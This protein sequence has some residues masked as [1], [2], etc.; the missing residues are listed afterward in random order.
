MSNDTTT[1]LIFFRSFPACGQNILLFF[2][3]IYWHPF[4]DFLRSSDFR[5]RF[6]KRAC[7]YPAA[8]YLRATK[9]AVRCI[10]AITWKEG[11]PPPPAQFC[12]VIVNEPIKIIHKPKVIGEGGNRPEIL[13]TLMFSEVFYQIIFLAISNSFSSN[14]VIPDHQRTAASDWHWR[15]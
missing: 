13:P 3:G 15:E 8:T 10:I 11:S 14:E 7:I 4:T 2:L 9:P 5:S 6:D 12:H 1:A